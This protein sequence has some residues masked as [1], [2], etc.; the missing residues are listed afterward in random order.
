MKVSVSCNNPSISS[1][2]L[3]WW[4]RGLEDL[5]SFFLVV[6]P[7]VFPSST[8]LKIVYLHHFHIPA[9]GEKNG[10]RRKRAFLLWALSEVACII[11]ACVLIDKNLTIRLHIT[12][13]RLDNAPSSTTVKEKESLG[14][15]WWC[16]G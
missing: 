8:K 11:S 3:I 12:T 5:G 2:E 16:S 4:F 15:P 1:S 13:E 14:L 7:K 6:L 9:G 10:E